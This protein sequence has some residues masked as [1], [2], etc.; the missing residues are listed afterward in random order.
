MIVDFDYKAARI[1]AEIWRMRAQARENFDGVRNCISTDCRIIAT[2]KAHGASAI[3]T[4]HVDIIKLARLIGYPTRSLPLVPPK[5]L[6]LFQ[7]ESIS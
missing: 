4:E 3:Y 1:A 6:N 7:Q 5:P 2:A